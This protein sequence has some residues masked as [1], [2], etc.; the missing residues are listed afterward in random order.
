M[1]KG[2]QTKGRRKRGSLEIKLN[3]LQAVR[4]EAKPTN[5]AYNS[6]L[7]WLALGFYL[8]RLVEEKLVVKNGDGYYLTERGKAA[9]VLAERCY[10]LLGVEA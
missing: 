2:W 8:A 1:T 5:I 9:L 6:R 7:N 4:S 10:S 3:V